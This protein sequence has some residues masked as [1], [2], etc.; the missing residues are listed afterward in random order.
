LG[1]VERKVLER[2]ERG[3]GRQRDKGGERERERRKREGWV[4]GEDALDA[5]C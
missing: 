3:R 2:R 5:V 4:G 1:G